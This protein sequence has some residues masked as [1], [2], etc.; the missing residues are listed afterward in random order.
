MSCTLLLEIRAKFLGK[1]IINAIACFSAC[2]PSEIFK[3]VAKAASG[4]RA[5]LDGG[6]QRKNAILVPRV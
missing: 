1:N 6:C 4:N 2:I 3:Q 5:R